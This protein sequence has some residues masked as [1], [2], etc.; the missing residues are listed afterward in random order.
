[1]SAAGRR[2]PVEFDRIIIKN[3]PNGIVQLK[4]VGRAELGA[5]TYGGQLKFNGIDTVGIGVQQLSNANALEVD[6]QAKAALANYRK[7]SRLA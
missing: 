1:M 6:R 3:T 7:L 4:D 2:T 5:E